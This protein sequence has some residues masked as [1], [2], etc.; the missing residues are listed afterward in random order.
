VTGPNVRPPLRVEQAMRL[1][2]AL[3]SLA[4]LRALVLGRSQRDAQDHWA[5][6][7]S[8]LTLGKRTVEPGE[9]R[10]D[11]EGLLDEVHAHLAKV[12]DAYVTALE[13]Y[14]A[15]D[16]SGA[17]QALRDAG[18]LEEGVG[19][20]SQAR[21][22]YE[23]AGRL[24]AELRDRKPEIETLAR[25]ASL[26]AVL[27]H[28]S[29]AARHF[30]R[31]LVLAESEFDQPGAIQ[32]CDGLGR[33]AL[34]RGE[35]TGAQAWFTRGLRLAE[36]GGDQ[37]VIGRQHHRLA[38]LALARGD[39]TA[40]Q[41][42]LKRAEE[43]FEQV[44]DAAELAAALKTR[45]EL[46]ARLGRT[47]NAHAA[48]REALAWATRV[49]EVTTV[50]LAVRLEVARLHMATGRYLEAEEELR[51]AEQAAV[52]RRRER[53]VG[54]V[55]ALIGRLRGLQGDQT[56]FV[57]FEEALRLCRGAEGSPAVEGD[58]LRAYG[59][60]C[61]AMGLKDEARAYLE[62]AREVFEQL[63]QVPD[64]DQVRAELKEVSA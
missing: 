54:R 44:Q 26:S 57:F 51:R 17:V 10:H 18:A 25:L 12:Y 64:R 11:V 41:E 19:R 21:A 47:A 42:P 50:D 39:L 20:L 40:A 5:G 24:A 59:E 13:R 43:C 1:L 49:R 15:G 27:G 45:G 36:A 46:E 37:L 55:Y 53:W 16:T 6:G 32:A 23:C 33:I 38:R 3:E 35:W 4:P 52:A 14:D 62:R 28:F 7:G 63:G 2:P 9:L 31:A 34:A 30:Q 56:G 61:L 58:V 29:E 22:W 48:Y 8:Y 60:F